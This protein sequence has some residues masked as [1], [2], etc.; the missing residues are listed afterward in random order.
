MALTKGN[1]TT[2]LKYFMWSIKTS[3]S[4]LL[5]ILNILDNK[6]EPLSKRL[7]IADGILKS[8]ELSIH[9]RE[10]LLLKWIVR[11][12][13]DKTTTEVWEVF[14]RWLD[15]EQIKQ[16]SRSDIRGADILYILNVSMF[17]N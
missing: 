13:K 17:M 4:F 5:E 9:H 3:I 2:L 16:L 14:D 15:A 8:G 6:E 1:Y 7:K 10:S 11:S 12:T